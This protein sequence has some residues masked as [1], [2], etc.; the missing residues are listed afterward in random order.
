MNDLQNHLAVLRRDFHKFAESKWREFRTTSKIA[1]IL[2]ELN[3]QL[4]IGKEII[5]PERCIG[6]PSEEERKCEIERAISQGANKEWINK[7]K[8]Y[9]GVIG[10]WDTGK[11]GPTIGF[12]FDIDAL[13]GEES[14]DA[15]HKP[16]KEGFR[17]VNPY[18]HSCGHDGHTAIG[19]GLAYLIKERANELS[20]KIVLIFQPSEEGGRGAEAILNSNF[21]IDLDYFYAIH[22]CLSYNCMPMKTGMIAGGCDDFLDNR[23]Y[24]V[25]FKGKAAHPAGAAQNG[26][27]ALLA[28]CTVAL[29]IHSIAHH[30]EGLMRVNVGRVDAGVARNVIA[31]NAK[32]EL[33]VRGGNSKVAEYVNKRC[34]KIIETGAAMYDLEFELISKGI[35]PSAKSDDELKELVGKAIE[36]IDIFNEFYKTGNVGGSDD[37]ACW[38]KDTQ[39]KGGK[40]TYIGIGADSTAPLHNQKFDFDEKVLLPSSE[41]LYKLIKLSTNKK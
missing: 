37:A 9:S 8:G 39:S 41:M 6:L 25:Y 17:S 11:K 16:V 34:T 35:T 27:N 21:K 1:E 36:D 12:R 19:L 28:A 22:L 5:Q 29:N 24:D 33:E 10:I 4:K 14:D 32:L 38:I 7:M 2:D 31:P 15:T 40:A 20:G 26:K 18:M 13:E 30:E 23:R 3:F